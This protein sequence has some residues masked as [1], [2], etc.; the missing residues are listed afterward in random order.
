MEV[1]RFLNG[2]AAAIDEERDIYQ[3]GAL[4]KVPY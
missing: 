4:R 1:K 2:E 3:C